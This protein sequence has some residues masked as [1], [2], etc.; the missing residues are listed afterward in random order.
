M[1][2]TKYICGCT[3]TACHFCDGGL[4]WCSVCHG[5]EASL[6]TDCPGRKMTGPEQDAVQ[7]GK[8][9]FKTGVWEQKGG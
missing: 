2:H 5:A 8:L 6:P 4:F 9:D 1:S 7:A 3:R